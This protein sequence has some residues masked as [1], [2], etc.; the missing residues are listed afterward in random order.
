MA[1]HHIKKPKSVHPNRNRVFVPEGEQRPHPDTGD[2]L[3]LVSGSRE[4]MEDP[5]YWWESR[6]GERFPPFDDDA[7]YVDVLDPT[8]TIAE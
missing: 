1:R 2:T 8:R 6:S 5:L 3:T 4:S 7:E